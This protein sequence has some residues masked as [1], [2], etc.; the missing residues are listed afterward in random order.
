NISTR[1]ITTERA[2]LRLLW[3]FSEFLMSFK[4]PSFSADAEWRLIQLGRLLDGD[5]NEVASL[6]PASF[7]VRGGRIVSYAD[8]DLTGDRGALAGKLPAVEIVCGPTVHRELG[9]KVLRELCES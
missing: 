9:I 1:D 7:R 3:W 6:W 2:R 8:L 4:H 5:G